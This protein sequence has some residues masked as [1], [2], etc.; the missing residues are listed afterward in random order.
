[1]RKV[2]SCCIY[3][4]KRL[5]YQG[6]SDVVCRHQRFVQPDASRAP[7]PRERRSTCFCGYEALTASDGKPP[8]EEQHETGANH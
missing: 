7:S 6:R 2:E 3:G 5:D 8:E 1:M 4:V